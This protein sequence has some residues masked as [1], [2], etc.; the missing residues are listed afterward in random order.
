MTK[1]DDVLSVLEGANAAIKQNR[2]QRQRKTSQHLS[3]RL[4]ETIQEE[5]T[6]ERTLT[7]K[8][9]YTVKEVKQ[10][11]ATATVKNKANEG[12]ILGLVFGNETL[13]MSW[14]NQK[15]ILP[16]GQVTSIYTRFTF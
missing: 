13:G 2:F 15:Y 16:G 7:V 4:F 11:L 1:S 14:E 3:N 5:G 8:E 10:I 9:Y 12:N 6:K